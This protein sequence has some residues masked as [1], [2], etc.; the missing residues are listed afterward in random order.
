[1]GIDFGERR[2][3]IALSDPTG[4]LATPLETLERRAGKRPPLKALEALARKHEVNRI[5]VGLPLDL[6]GKE[7]SW[8]H[9]V[10][11]AAD[12]LG[13]RLGTP[14][15]YI[16]ERLSSV[17]ARRAVREIGLQKG[18]RESKGR[19]DRAAAALILQAWLDA[20]KREARDHGDAS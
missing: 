17:R 4:T 14:V 20:R 13:R 2:T 9:Q 7:N 3:G 18:A 12:E 16:D 10:R 15:E 8:C 19:V 5:V 1:M 11:R 6:R